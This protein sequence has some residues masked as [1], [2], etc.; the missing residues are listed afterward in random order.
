[1]NEQLSRNE[2]ALWGSVDID[3]KQDIAILDLF[4]YIYL[5]NKFG[6]WAWRTNNFIVGIILAAGSC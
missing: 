1:M 3:L 2:Y 6:A 5:Y 4:I